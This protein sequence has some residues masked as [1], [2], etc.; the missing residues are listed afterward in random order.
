MSMKKKLPGGLGTLI[1][2]VN[3]LGMKF[4]IWYEP[5]MISPDSELFRTHPDW[6]VHVPGRAPS[7]A[8]NQYVLDVSRDDVRDNIFKQ[9]S[10][11]LSKYKID[12]LKWDFNRNISEAGSALLPAERSK[13]FFHRFILGTY[14]LMD[15]FTKA[16]PDILFENCSG[17]GGRF[18]PG[19]LYYSPQIWASD[20]TD[21]IERLTIQFGTSLCY[22]AQTVGAHV[23]ANGR[24]GYETKGNVA[25]WG[26]FGYELDPTKLT[27]SEKEIIKKQVSDYHKYYALTHYGDL[28][29]IIDPYFDQF[30]C[31]WGLVAPDKSEALFTAVIMRKIESGLFI[32]KLAGL[33]KNKFYKNESDGEI[34]S[35]ALLMNSGINISDAACNDGDSIQI[36]LTEYKKAK[37]QQIQYLQYPVTRRFHLYP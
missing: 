16:F 1:D 9:M 12:Y 10:E 28:Y 22:P 19:M 30:R 27:D 33:D 15:R 35:G 21:P 14:D 4:G 18:D 5:E 13:E 34:Y 20:N 29:R 3:E 7:I 11:V 26:T 6:F 23:S 8:R 2:K 31:A 36:Y 32:L 24:T 37:N 25:Q 17:G